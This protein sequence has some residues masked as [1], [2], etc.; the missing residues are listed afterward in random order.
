MKVVVITFLVFAS[1]CNL[2]A[3]RKKKPDVQV[4]VDNF[5]SLFLQ[6]LKQMKIKNNIMG[7]LERLLA[8][9]EIA[10][11]QAHHD[12]R[13]ELIQENKDNADK[14]T[15][16]LKSHSNLNYIQKENLRDLL[17]EFESA[18]KI[19]EK[20]PDSNSDSFL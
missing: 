9:N 11:T 8:G 10:P 19:L 12:L 18:R 4:E 15:Q 14:I 5:M 1:A 2:I 16:F 20:I 6:P 13:K 3:M 7:R 17:S